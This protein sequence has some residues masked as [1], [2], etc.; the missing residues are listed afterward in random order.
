MFTDG[1]K[2]DT[3][4]GF[5]VVFPTFGRGC[6]LPVVPS[7]FTAQLSAI[8]LALQIILTFPV[9]FTIFRDSR[10]ALSPLNSYAPSG[11]PLILFALEL[12][13]LLYK[14][15]YCV[16]FCWVPGH[17]GVPGNERADRLAR[18]AAN[19]TALPS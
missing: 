11:N 12:L 7:F 10:N 5:G 3:G 18:E 2:S 4:V 19:R 9:N 16:E 13:Y 15:G 17:V 8:I 6:S 1:S 14:R